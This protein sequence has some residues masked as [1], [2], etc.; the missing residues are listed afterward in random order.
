MNTSLST[1]MT[2]LSQ[3][4][5][6]LRDIIERYLEGDDQPDDHEQI[7]QQL[8]AIA[9]LLK[10][11]DFVAGVEACH[12]AAGC[13]SLLAPGDNNAAGDTLL[14]LCLL[15][16]RLCE[17]HELGLSLKPQAFIRFIDE[18]K[19]QITDLESEDKDPAGSRKL[20]KVLR[21]LY[22]RQLLRLIREK[23]PDKVLI[24]LIEV[25]DEVREALPVVW[26][27]EWRALSY[28]LS[29]IQDI[30]LP[31]NSHIHRLLGAIDRR[32][33]FVPTQVHTDPVPILPDLS[34]AIEGLV[35]G[36]D[37]LRSMRPAEL[38]GAKVESIS[39]GTLSRLVGAVREDLLRLHDGYERFAEKPTELEH[40]EGQSEFLQKLAKVLVLAEF[41]ELAQLAVKIS[42]TFEKWCSQQVLAE[43]ESVLTVAQ[44]LWLFETTVQNIWKQPLQNLP[45]S[46]PELKV[47]VAVSSQRHVYETLANHLVDSRENIEILD[48]NVSF[49]D[50]SINLLSPINHALQLARSEVNWLARLIT[51]IEKSDV[52]VSVCTD[53]LLAQEYCLR[54]QAEGTLPAESIL[55]QTEQRMLDL[56][57][58]IM[59]PPVVADEAVV[60]LTGIAEVAL[61]PE[62]ESVNIV[63][64]LFAPS[65]L[66]ADESETSL[67]APQ[68]ASI[69]EL[70]LFT[71]TAPSAEKNNFF[72]SA[73]ATKT[74]GNNL[75]VTADNVTLT[76]EPTS[77]ELAIEKV[78]QPWKVRLH[79]A[80]DDWEFTG[81]ATVARTVLAQIFYELYEIAKQASNQVATE[82]ARGWATWLKCEPSPVHLAHCSALIKAALALAEQAEFCDRKDLDLHLNTLSQTFGSVPLLAIDGWFCADSPTSPV[83]EVEVEPIDPDIM[84]AFQ[85]EAEDLLLHAEDLMSRPDLGV[86]ALAEICRIMHT[87]KGGARMVDLEPLATLAHELETLLERTPV[88]DAGVSS[89][90]RAQLSEGLDFL[91]RGVSD[92]ALALAA[93]HLT[94][95]EG[96]VSLALETKACNIETEQVAEGDVAQLPELVEKLSRDFCDWQLDR[97]QPALSKV[98]AQ[99]LA[100]LHVVAKYAAQEDLSELSLLVRQLF[101]L[102]LSDLTDSAS[103]NLLTHCMDTLPSLVIHASNSQN[104]RLV[105]QLQTTIRA[106]L[107]ERSEPVEAAQVEETVP[108]EMQ[109]LQMS[110]QD[111]TV[112]IGCKVLDEIMVQVDEAALSQERI[113][114]QLSETLSLLGELGQSVERFSLYMR[115]FGADIERAH[116]VDTESYHDAQTRLMALCE[117]SED[118]LNLRRTLSTGLNSIQINLE[119]Q[120]RFHEQAQQTLLSSRLAKFGVLA[121]RLRRVAKRNADDLSKRVGLV[122]DGEDVEFDRTVLENM[123]APLEHLIRNSISHGI[124]SPELRIKRNKPEIGAIHISALREG[125]EV[126]IRLHD[127]GAGFDYA[128]IKAKAIKQGLITEQVEPSITD[129]DQ[130]L[131]K[132]GF[133]TAK[134]V[135]QISGRGVGMDV[136]NSAIHAARGRLSLFSESGKGATFELRFPLALAATQALLVE[137]GGQ[138]YALPAYGIEGVAPLDLADFDKLEQADPHEVIINGRR[139]PLATLAQRLGMPAMPFV[140]NPSP[141]VVLVRDHEVRAALYVDRVIGQRKVLIKPIG[142]PLT[143]LAWFTGA[144]LMDNGYVAMV[145]DPLTLVRLR[146]NQPQ[147][148]M[149]VIQAVSATALVVDDS[150]T[151]RRSTQHL[152]EQAGFAVAVMRDGLE[153]LENLE[154]INPNLIV[155]DIDMPRMDGFEL[156]SHIRRHPQFQD[157]PVIMVTSRAGSKHRARAEKMGASEYLIKPYSPDALLVA[158]QRHTNLQGVNL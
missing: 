76:E 128:A 78:L 5:D 60:D 80:R 44:W 82:L 136:V 11:T 81:D 89:E 109:P 106:Q 30:G 47:Y 24:T 127:D 90:I 66:Q 4:L 14:Y 67:L 153:A 25:C 27:L 111:E 84:T 118:L 46:L 107:A 157:C 139:Y 99:Q 100:T 39:A 43:P 79:T 93:R 20:L 108:A 122:F 124:E 112:R 97:N 147:I 104:S 6:T 94:N 13:V 16:S 132:P 37:W 101:E 116:P 57:M 23:H 88:T 113:S 156:L 151:M 21:T 61:L 86:K 29:R 155:L 42:R 120:A 129:L 143:Q 28:Y 146:Q 74:E 15:L 125:S 142:T 149:E 75:V 18:T 119:N 8:S 102:S 3:E 92:N 134:R 49:R 9:V 91:S 52:T 98:I 110:S 22:Q 40:L 154:S 141:H 19:A 144:T 150:V 87:I 145:L 77:G 7:R 41:N 137:A 38:S 54:R 152:L 131:L 65:V 53:I 96:V 48:S 95:P 73:V 12:L 17:D 133:S 35:G 158:V 70:D 114:H 115:D 56:E 1:L 135:S 45:Q 63:D 59:P 51:C 83:L 64:D 130:C 58:V 2:Q 85:E 138:V 69:D 55:E 140:S 26:Q 72:S 121:D 33:K 123:V 148:A 71:E 36:N 68:P 117:V 103:I 50:F 34:S 62:I 105:Q 126:L 32:L 31:I 10:K